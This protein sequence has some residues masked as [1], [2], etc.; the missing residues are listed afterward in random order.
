MCM[1]NDFLPTADPKTATRNM[2]G[3]RVQRKCRSRDH[4]K[5]VLKS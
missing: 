2:D 4:L 1:S 5:S 3:Y